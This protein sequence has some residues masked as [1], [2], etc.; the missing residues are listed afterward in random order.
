MRLLS[1]E[2]IDEVTSKCSDN[3]DNI[4]GCFTKYSTSPIRMSSHL[5]LQ[6]L[7]QVNTKYAIVCID[8]DSITLSQI[9]GFELDVTHI[10]KIYFDEIKNIR[11]VNDIKGGKIV[12][13]KTEKNKYKFNMPKKTKV[14]NNF[15]YR[16]VFLDKLKLKMNI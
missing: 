6:S 15:E 9:E 2:L 12:A 10:E 7:I 3:C 1:N 13:F 16:E 11:I 4:H 8:D 5:F 14:F